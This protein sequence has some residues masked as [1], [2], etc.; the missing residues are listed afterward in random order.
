MSYAK[1]CLAFSLLYIECGAVAKIWP[2]STT[3]NNKGYQGDGNYVYHHLVY[4]T[5]PLD[6]IHAYLVPGMMMIPDQVDLWKLSDCHASSPMNHARW[7]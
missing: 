3:L 2:H 4:I 6:V 7:C 5:S 1:R